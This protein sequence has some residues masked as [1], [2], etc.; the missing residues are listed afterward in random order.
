MCSFEEQQRKL[1]EKRQEALERFRQRKGSYPRMDSGV[2]ADKAES[3]SHSDGFKPQRPPLARAPPPGQSSSGTA[4][5]TSSA[6][7]KNVSLS[8]YQELPHSV[9]PQLVQ[10]PPPSTKHEEINK[11]ERRVKERLFEEL[12]HHSSSPVLG[13]SMEHTQPNHARSAGHPTTTAATTSPSRDR[14]PRPQPQ[15]QSTNKIRR[16]VS[17]QH[18]LLP[19]S[20]HSVVRSDSSEWT[21]YTCAPPVGNST[22][23]LPH[24]TSENLLKPNRTVVSEFD[25]YSGNL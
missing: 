3:L 25:P 20:S 12:A 11:M 24:N 9:T 19:K 5:V 14:K 17:P 15:C 8:E 16:P 18:P 7:T 4:T 1:D 6:S 2:S 21:E 10:S 23:E 22:T 13:S